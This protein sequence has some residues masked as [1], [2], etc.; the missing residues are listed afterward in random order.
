MKG[1]KEEAEVIA[2]LDQLDG[3][4]HLCVVAW[5]G[6]Y[7]KMCKLYGEPNITSDTGNM[8]RWKVPMKAL[9]FR[10]ISTSTTPRKMA[11]GAFGRHQK[12]R[13]DAKLPFDGQLGMARE[14]CDA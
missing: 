2:R 3:C 6:M 9:S 14:D 5:P 13:S 7:R 11:V 4:L 8:A 10:R 1:R 12:P